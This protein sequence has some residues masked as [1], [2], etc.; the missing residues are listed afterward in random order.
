MKNFNLLGKS[1]DQICCDM[2]RDPDEQSKE[3][4]CYV[5]D[6]SWLKKTLL[7]IEFEEEKASHLSARAIYRN[8]LARSTTN[9]RS[10]YLFR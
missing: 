4:W 3:M 1:R 2:G 7:F 9:S 6:T 10:V 8:P 5:L